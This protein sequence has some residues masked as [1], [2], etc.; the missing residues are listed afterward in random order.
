[1][2][3]RKLKKQSKQKSEKIQNQKNNLPYARNVDKIKAFITDMFMI[4]IPILYLL[5][6]VV[7]NGKD[8]FQSSTIGPLTG[9]VLY[10][11]ISS[12]LIAKFGQTPG[13]KAYTMK[14]VD[15]KTQELISFPRAL[16]RYISFIFSATFVLGLFVGVYRKDNASLH[17]LIAKTVV[18]E[19]KD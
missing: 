1:M 9:V 6:Y 13:N 16:L 15:A 10:G 2:R 8:E 3:F 11:L 19:V 17:D 5:T 18:L 4:Y 12:V 14:V 7:L